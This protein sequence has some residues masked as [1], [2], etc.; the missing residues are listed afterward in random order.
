MI[1]LL[2]VEGP[3]AWLASRAGGVTAYVALSI[4]IAF[5][6]FLS[7]G[8]ADAW[9]ARARSIELH[10]WLSRA[11]LLLV[12]AH[13]SALLFDRVQPFD[14]VDLVVPF[15]ARYRPFAVGLGVVAVWLTWMVHVSFRVRQQLGQR[16]W[17]TLH[18]ASFGVYGLA[19]AHGVLAG[20][21]SH[22]AGV[23]AIYLVSAALIGLLL[24]ARVV[25]AA[26]SP[27]APAP[28]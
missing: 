18:F 10:R 9:I 13:A 15:V 3:G 2:R 1:E 4:E 17:R 19:T 6:M 7:T 5:G 25:S 28:R 14:V 20:T 24:L 27:R 8:A 11:T 22:R 26:K 12:V 16:L 21:D 23:R